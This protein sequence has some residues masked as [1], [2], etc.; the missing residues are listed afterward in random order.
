M[1]VSCP[2]GLPSLGFALP[3]LF[4]SSLFPHPTVSS[5][6][7][8]SSSLALVGLLAAGG[9]KE[10]ARDESWVARKLQA[11][12]GVCRADTTAPLLPITVSGYPLGRR[13]WGWGTCCRRALGLSG[14]FA[15]GTVEA[16]SQEVDT[17]LST[18]MCAPFALL[19]A[20]FPQHS[21]L[22]RSLARSPQEFLGSLTEQGLGMPSQGG[23]WGSL[24]SR[25]MGS[26]QVIV[27]VAPCSHSLN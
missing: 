22:P 4:L 13:S 12:G 8:Q 9:R 2:T 23:L 1:S 14:H 20:R 7:C 11:E 18:G 21:H 10:A 17:G 5:L 15:D 6:R 27:G 24:G 25:L 3:C 26:S 19:D 16:R